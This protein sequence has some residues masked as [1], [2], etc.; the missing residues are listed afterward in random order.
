ML[1]ELQW[2]EDCLS[3]EEEACVCILCNSVLK[4]YLCELSSISIFSTMIIAFE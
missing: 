4:L 2:R 3:V 1:I